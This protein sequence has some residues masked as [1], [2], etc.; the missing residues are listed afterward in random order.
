MIFLD[1]GLYITMFKSQLVSYLCC[2]WPQMAIPPA[3][4]PN[5]LVWGK[6]T[7]GNHSVDVLI[8]Q[9]QGFPRLSMAFHGFPS[10]LFP[11]FSHPAIAPKP[12]RPSVDA[13]APD[14][15]QGA[16]QPQSFPVGAGGRRLAER[17]V[18]KTKQYTYIY[19]IICTH[20]YFLY[21]L[22]IYLSIYLI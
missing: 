20:M 2:G 18:E 5:G 3:K 15:P 1:S 22:S 9:V 8:P 17:H 12:R 16:L 21:N 19:I 7:T 6:K 10:R 4:H 11:S 13:T 14:T